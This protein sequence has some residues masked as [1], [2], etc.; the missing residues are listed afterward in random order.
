VTLVEKGHECGLTFENF[1]GEMQ[2]GDHVEAYKEIE[3]K[4]TKFNHRPGVH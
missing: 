3:G 2:P 4:V 1:D